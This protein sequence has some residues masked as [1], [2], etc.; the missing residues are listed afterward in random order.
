M[1]EAA[2]KERAKDERPLLAGFGKRNTGN[3]GG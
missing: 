1:V 3:L 2:S